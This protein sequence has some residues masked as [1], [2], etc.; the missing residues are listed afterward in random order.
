MRRL[1]AIC[2]RIRKQRG[3]IVAS[4]AWRI[5]I[6]FL[7]TLLRQVVIN[8]ADRKLLIHSRYLWLYPRRHQIPFESIKA[9]TY[10]YEDMSLDAEIAFA[11][12][13]FDWFTVG[14]RMKD[15]SELHLFNFVGDGTFSNHGPFPDWLYIEE[16]ACDLS[17]SQEKESRVFADLLSTLIGVSVIPPRG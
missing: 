13:S 9:V 12:D 17:G 16:F 11:H 4:T 10:G 2:P 8:P 14:L 7:A 6:L 3:C 15:D 5:R 1:F